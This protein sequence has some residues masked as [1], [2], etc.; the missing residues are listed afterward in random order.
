M[1]K[2]V[3]LFAALACLV[4]STVASNAEAGA[5]GG[6]ERSIS[7][8]AAR[9]EDSRA[10]FLRAGEVGRVTVSGDGDTD[11]VCLLVSRTGRVVAVDDDSSGSCVLEVTPRRSDQYRVVVRNLGR[12]YNEYVLRTN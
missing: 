9:S 7:T 10:V 11:L 12:T 1:R 3:A 4:A 6:P 5:V 8:V 2:V